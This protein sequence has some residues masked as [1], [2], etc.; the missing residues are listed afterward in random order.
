MTADIVIR[1]AL[2]ENVLMIPEDVIQKKEGKLMVQVLKGN[3][4][5]EREI[6]TGIEGNN[7]V[8]V[9]SGL[10]EGKKAAMP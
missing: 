8:E 9:I 6:E 10:S 4:L 2:K 7:M 1:T 5:Q 3:A